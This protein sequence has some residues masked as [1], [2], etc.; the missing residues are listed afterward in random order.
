MSGI[1]HRWLRKRGLAAGVAAAAA[2]VALLVGAARAPGAV[3]CDFNAGTGV[4]TVTVT[5]GTP[6]PTLS[7][8]ISPGTEI[9]V[10]DD[11][12]FGN[13]T[14]VCSSGTPTDTTTSSIVVDETASTQSTA[15]RLDFQRGR[16]AP[17]AGGETGTPEIEVS[18]VTDTDGEDNLFVRGQAEVADQSFQFGAIS[19]TMIRG[20][21]NGDDD[22][23]DVEV[24]DLESTS[25]EPG[26]GNDTITMDGTGD[27]SFTGPS[28]GSLTVFPTIGNDTMAG[29][30]AMGGQNTFNGGPGDDTITGGAGT[31]VGH[32]ELGNDTYDGGAGG[33]DF[34]SYENF[35]TANGV[36]LDMSIT[37]PQNTGPDTGTDQVTN[38]ERIVGSNGPD[39]L[40]GTSGP[41]TIFGGNN[42]NDT[43]DDV[44]NGLEGAD[45]LVARKGN[46]FLLGGQGSDLLD[47]EEG[48]DT[49]SFALGSDSAVNFDLDLALTGV[50]QVTG[51][52]DNDTLDDGPAAGVDHEMENITGSPFAGDTL[53]GN[54]GPNTIDIHDGFTDTINCLGDTDTAISDEIGV[55]IVSLC[56]TE[57]NAPQTSIASGPADGAT[58]TTRT[59]GYSLTADEPSSFAVSVD[60]GAFTPCAPS[61]S[62]QSLSEGPHTLAFR[63]I[64]LDENQNEDLTPATRAL[65]VDTQAPSAIIRGRGK[66]ATEERR[67]RVKFKLTSPEP[68]SSFLC[69]LDGKAFRPCSSPFRARVGIGS[70]KLRVRATDSVGN[71]DPSPTVR[72]FRV[73]SE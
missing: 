41:N 48:V 51:G 40:T 73:I 14:L 10:D 26:T 68:G 15:L 70:H 60:G 36:T 45:S 4:L 54:A 9:K 29:G 38:A 12:N 47:G 32:I 52:A 63:A 65:V 5:D 23:D 62:P 61:C 64:D 58:I 28:P 33:A 72:R 53:T 31:D 71:A 18:F 66:L 56:E 55:D 46:D 39:R 16:L 57:D 11:T 19:G 37:T 2:C 17:G 59:P 6:L 69:S 27:A 13:G 1:E 35:A 43:G 49:A 3:T 44:L 8:D 7:H 50:A 24:T 34:A 21:L 67:A 22:A 25:T 30:P 42:T 20:D